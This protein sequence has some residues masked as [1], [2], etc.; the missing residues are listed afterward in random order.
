[1]TAPATPKGLKV[2]G[3]G[4]WQRTVKAFDLSDLELELLAE[5]CRLLDEVDELRASVEA[6]GM[7]VKGSTGQLRVHPAVGEL[8]QHRLALGRLLAQLELPDEEGESLPSPT[9][10]RGRKAANRRWA[11]HRAAEARISEV[12]RGSA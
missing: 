5:V 12:S 8:R 9:V 6:E 10:A 3:R 1:M 2:R 4:F 7:T 11:P